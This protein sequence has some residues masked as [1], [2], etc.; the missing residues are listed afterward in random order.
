VAVQAEAIK[1]I[2]ATGMRPMHTARQLEV[3]RSSVY[4]LLER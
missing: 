4:R 3:A 2:H 1:A